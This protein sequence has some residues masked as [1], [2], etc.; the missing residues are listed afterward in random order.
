MPYPSDLFVHDHA[1]A[2]EPVGPGV[3]RKI[4]AYDERLM[5]VKVAFEAGGVGSVHQ[6]AHSQTSYVESGEFSVTIG[7]QTQVL[8]TGDA[9]YIPPNVPHGATALRAGVL[10]DTFSPLREDFISQ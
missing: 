10:L 1:V 2:W 3:R 6:H 9:F 7:A 8:Q 5:L 4:L